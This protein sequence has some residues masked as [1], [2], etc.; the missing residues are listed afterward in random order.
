MLHPH[1]LNKKQRKKFV[2]KINQHS[3]RLYKVEN[4]KLD[5][6]TGGMVT[7]LLFIFNL[8]N[9]KFFQN[10]DLKRNPSHGEVCN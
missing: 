5:T 2:R 4:D 1:D 9:S 6:K 3:V 7:V 8:F 10:A